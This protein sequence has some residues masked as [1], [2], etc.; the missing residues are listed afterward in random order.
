MGRTHPSL[1]RLTLPSLRE[2]DKEV[3]AWG[4]MRGESSVEFPVSSEE[5][6]A[7]CP[8]RTTRCL[9]LRIQ[10]DTVDLICKEHY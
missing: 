1:A 6:I 4:R 9:D 10:M 3:L 8:R 5:C 2:P 7:G